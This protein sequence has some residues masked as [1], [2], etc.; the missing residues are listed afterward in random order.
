MI[1]QLLNFI[2]F[3]VVMLAYSLGYSQESGKNKTDYLRS[4]LYLDLISLEEA[5]GDEIPKILNDLPF[6]DKY[7]NHNNQDTE[8]SSFLNMMQTY[9]RIGT[10][11]E[12]DI[13]KIFQ[14]YI[15]ESNL[16]NKLIAIWFNRQRDGTFNMETVAERG[17]YDASQLEADLA[18]QTLRGRAA[19]ADAGENLIQNTFVVLGLMYVNGNHKKF[20]I[21]SNVRLYRLNWDKEKAA[22]FYKDYWIPKGSF[23]LEKRR[24]FEDMNLF[25]LEYIGS[26]SHTEV[27]KVSR[28][29]PILELPDRR[30]FSARLPRQ[31]ENRKRFKTIVTRHFDEV[32]A[33]LQK[34]HPVFRVLTPLSS[35]NPLSA[36]IGMKEGLK[37]G[38]KFEVL[39]QSMNKETGQIILKRKGTITVATGKVWDNRYNAGEQQADGALQNEDYTLF[40]GS[41]NKYASGMLIRQIN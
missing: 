41:S 14:N 37:G 10:G 17:F 30:Y 15:D 27:I 23:N 8:S 22:Q 28:R 2:L 5:F 40:K 24:A 25:D 26:Q 39:E 21:G 18:G 36:Q 3:Y 11:A 33:N 29:D 12:V 20:A 38:E 4:S 32:Y 9:V 1:R 35:V 31:I 19:L 34:K 16:E 6:P 7:N 13:D